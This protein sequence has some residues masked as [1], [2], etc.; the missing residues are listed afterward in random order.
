MNSFN[1]LREKAACKKIG[2]SRSSFWDAQNP[3]SKNFDA[4]MPQKVKCGVRSVGWLEHELNLW[5]EQQAAKR[6]QKR[7]GNKNHV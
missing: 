1:I 5:I 7:Q 3:K 6:E 2:K 4:T